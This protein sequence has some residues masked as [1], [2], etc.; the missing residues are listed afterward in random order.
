ML[1]LGEGP[2]KGAIMNKT[3][4]TRPDRPEPLLRFPGTMAAYF[5]VDRGLL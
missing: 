2:V 1:G 5:K 3:L 4:Q